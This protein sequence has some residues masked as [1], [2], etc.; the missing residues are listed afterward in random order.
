[1]TIETTTDTTQIAAEIA[2]DPISAASPDMS[3]AEFAALT[4]SIKTQG[5]LVP[6][7][8]HDGRVIDGRKRLAACKAL[9]IEPTVIEFVNTDPTVIA[10]DLNL[11]RTHYT[12]SQRAMFVG[13]ITAGLF[14]GLTAKQTF[15]FVPVPKTGC[16]TTPLSKVTVAAK[17]SLTIR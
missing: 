16:V 10:T 9:G 12:A 17:S 8:V 3:P 6:I 4:A 1:M 15:G 2:V 7:V 14:K 11:R 5:Q 13:K